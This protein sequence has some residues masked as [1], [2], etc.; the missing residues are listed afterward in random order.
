VLHIPN[1]IKSTILTPFDH[2]PFQKAHG[3]YYRMSNLLNIVFTS[4]EGTRGGLVV[5]A[6]GPAGHGPGIVD[7]VIIISLKGITKDTAAFTTG[8]AVM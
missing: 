4:E 8:T 6:G 5:L 1:Q 2:Y 7:Y 3:C